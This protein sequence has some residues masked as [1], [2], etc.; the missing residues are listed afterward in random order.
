LRRY[1]PIRWQK[2]LF[3]RPAVICKMEAGSTEFQSLLATGVP[4]GEAHRNP[5]RREVA[6]CRPI[7]DFPTHNCKGA[8]I[9]GALSSDESH[10]IGPNDF[11]IGLMEHHEKMA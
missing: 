4:W 11:L 2:L 9:P 5:S 6:P 10:N 8:Q 7:S 3:L 1:L